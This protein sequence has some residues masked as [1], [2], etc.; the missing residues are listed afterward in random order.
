MNFRIGLLETVFQN[1]WSQLY[2]NGRLA[3]DKTFD[4]GKRE[5]KSSSIISGMRRKVVW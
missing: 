3:R 1:D 4:E 2:L 5:I